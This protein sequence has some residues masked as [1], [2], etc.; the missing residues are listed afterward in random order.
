[1]LVW[2]DYASIPANTGLLR[3]LY[4]DLLDTLEDAKSQLKP[5]TRGQGEKE[6]QVT[7]LTMRDAG[8][9]AEVDAAVKATIG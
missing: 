1:M 4:K 7:A 2:V 6:K 5:I 8:Q 3:T 9:S